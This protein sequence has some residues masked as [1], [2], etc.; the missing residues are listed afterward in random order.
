MM[1]TTVL[2]AENQAYFAIK[3]KI[4][5]KELRPMEQIIEMD[6]A[7][8]SGLSRTSI[9]SAIRRLAYEGLVTIRPNKGAYVVNPSS[10]DIK[11]VFA[12]KRLLEVE[13]IRLACSNITKEQLSLMNE[14][15]SDEPQAFYAKDFIG[16]L[17]LNSKFHMI[18]AEAS[19][20][21]CYVK[22]IQELITQSNIFLIF[23]DDFMVTS[24]EESDAH[25]EHKSIYEAL[26]LHDEKRCV[27][28]MRQHSDTTFETL[29]V[30]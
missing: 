4:I 26:L 19:Q 6:V 10:K 11:D 13:A 1:E 2:S 30:R 28:E 24:F 20:N 16:F 25:I 22:Y 18:I 5:N 12:C 21:A 17:D 8:E 9:R 29:G 3:N 27:E 14:I 7:E 15:I 23:Y